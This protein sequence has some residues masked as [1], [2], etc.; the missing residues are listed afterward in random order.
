VQISSDG[1]SAAVLDQIRSTGFATLRLDSSGADRLADLFRASAAFFTSEEKLRYSVPK[2]TNG[3]RPHGSAHSGSP[4]KP[5]LND[6]FLY[7]KHRRETLP[8]HLEIGPF[9]DALEAYR[10]VAAMVVDN[11]IKALGKRYSY[12]HALPFTNAS[13]MQVN[14]FGAAVDRDLLQYSHEDAT[15][16]TVIT[17]NAAGL[18]AV[19]GEEVRPLTFAPGEVMVLPGS[20][21]TEMTGGEILPLYHQVRNHHILDRKSIMYFVSP[22]ADGPIEPYVVNDYNRDTDIQKRVKDN[23]QTFGLS[24]DFVA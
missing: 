2:R 12:Q 13:V 21:L 20:V 10:Q 15:L 5:D 7:W 6:S 9:L 19:F 11:V 18:E 23:P 3:Y 4:D 22:D 1:E 14:S 8:N 17:A 16:L 24:E